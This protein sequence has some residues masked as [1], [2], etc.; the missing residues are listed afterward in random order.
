M[1]KFIVK[2]LS[3]LGI[4]LVLGIV[5][6]INLIAYGNSGID[7]GK[8]PGFISPKVE[9]AEDIC[10]DREVLAYFFAQNQIMS[11]FAGVDASVQ[12]HLASDPP[13]LEGLSVDAENMRLFATA[14]RQVNPPPAAVGYHEAVVS[15]L[16]AYASTLEAVVEDNASV[17][18]WI[19]KMQSTEEQ[20]K[21]EREKLTSLC[22]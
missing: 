3:I 16:N 14:V 5:I 9:A 17:N 20:M 22:E 18:D 12:A 2:A 15:Y 4:A 8:I 10:T 13:D 19:K 11:K 7:F 21:S 1:K 6:S